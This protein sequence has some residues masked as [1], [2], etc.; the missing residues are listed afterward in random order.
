MT[1]QRTFIKI[2]NDRHDH[3]YFTQIPNILWFLNIS[4]ADFKL[5]NTFVKTCGWGQGKQCYKSTRYLAAEAGL[6][7]GQ[8]SSSKDSLLK[9]G[10]IT[11]DT[12][13]RSPKGWAVDHIRL[14][15]IWP[16]NMQFFEIHKSSDTHLRFPSIDDIRQHLRSVNERLEEKCSVSE[17]LEAKCS[18]TEHLEAKCSVSERKC[19]VSETEEEPFKKNPSIEEKEKEEEEEE[20]TPVSATSHSSEIYNLLSSFGVEEPALTKLSKNGLTPQQIR[21]WIMY[22]D[23]QDMMNRKQGYLVKRLQ[24]SDQPSADFLALGSLTDKQIAVLEDGANMRRWQGDWYMRQ[25]ELDEA[26]IDEDLAEMWYQELAR[27]N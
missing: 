26:G 21:G 25:D 11:R 3:R 2:A 18:L 13:R 14:V 6:S 5:Y 17:H 24:N 12:K 1:A 23:T 27:E 10:L 22:L 9:A 8:I 16:V 7:S 4:H 19:S 15:D 20:Q